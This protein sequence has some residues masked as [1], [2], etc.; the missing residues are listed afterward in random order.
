MKPAAYWQYLR[1]CYWGERMNEETRLPFWIYAIQ[2]G[3]G[4]L[5][6]LCKRAICR[7]RGH[8]WLEYDADPENG[9]HGVECTRC[10]ESHTI[11]W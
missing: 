5:A 10:N 11:Y 4:Y 2:S 8:A 6:W 9:C 3:C 7:L 1:W